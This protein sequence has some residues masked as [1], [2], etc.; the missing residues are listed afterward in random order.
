MTLPN[1][2]FLSFEIIVSILFLLCFVQSQKTGLLQVLELIAGALFGLLLEWTTIQQLQAYEYG[3]FTLMLGKVPVMV[4]VAWGVII[5]SAR[6]FSNATNLPEWGKPILNGFLALNIDL[7]MDAV[8]IRLGMWDWAIGFQKQYFGVPYANFWAWFW[9]VFSFTLALQLISQHRNSLI[10]WLAPVGAI[11]FGTLGVFTTNALIV[12]VIPYQWYRFTI[13]LVLGTALF[14]VLIM[15]PKVVR[16]PPRLVF[17]V[18][19]GFHGYF[20]VAGLISGVILQ[21]LFLL[22]ISILMAGIAFLG[23]GKHGALLT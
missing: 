9:V 12:F 4:G 5:Y 22:L 19:M 8:A 18:S 15:R 17:W 10:R 2:Y 7:S 1:I 20:L 14:S 11:A 13:A 3:R 16:T 6:L 21:P 23:H